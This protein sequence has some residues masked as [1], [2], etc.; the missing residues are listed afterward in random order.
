MDIADIKLSELSDNE[1]LEA[2]KSVEKFL[3]SVKAEY[4]DAK[5]KEEERS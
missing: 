3:T 2:Q 5:K 1:L 4:V